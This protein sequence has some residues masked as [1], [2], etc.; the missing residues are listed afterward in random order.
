[1]ASGKPRT[2][3]VQQ[4]LFRH[5]GKR[6]GAGRK[7]KGPRSSG[8]HRKRPHIRARHGLHVVLRVRPAI[9]NLRRPEMFRAIREA[10]VC[11]AVRERIRIVHVSVQRTH[12]HMIVEAANELVLARGMHGFQ[13]SA[14]RHINR[15]RPPRRPETERRPTG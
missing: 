5:G 7:P 14:A 3:H 4:A 2:R 6:K 12:V 13:I 8:P 10:S 15:D 9:G 1:M 11:A